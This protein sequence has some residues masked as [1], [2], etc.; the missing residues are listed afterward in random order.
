V[1]DVLVLCYH[2]VSDGWPSPL[3]IAPDRLEHHLGMLVRRGYRGATFERA[4]TAPPS[5]RTLAVTFDDGY[6]S[7]LTRAR[8]IL[9]RLGLPATVFVPT[10]FVGVDGPMQWPGI[11]HWVGGAHEEELRGMS[12]EQLGSLRDAGWEI[13]SHT[14]SHP[15][16]SSLGDRELAHELRESRRVCEDR[17][18]GCRTLALPYGDGDARVLAAARE[19]GYDAVAGLPGSGTPSAGW[20]RV[21]VYPADGPWR[22]AVKVARPV[23]RLRRSGLARPLEAAARLAPRRR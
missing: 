18:G 5:S 21:G 4:V 10:D 2:A 8:P 16:L 7:V 14:C 17:L 12:W 23:R 15:R 3:A 22:F 1:A 11:G 20:H 19:A 9:D 6:L 13:G